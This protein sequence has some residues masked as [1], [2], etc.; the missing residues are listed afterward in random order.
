MVLAGQQQPGV[1][2]AVQ[3]L[4]LVPTPKEEV[5]PL[6]TQE[7]LLPPMALMSIQ[8]IIPMAVMVLRSKLSQI[9]S[10]L[11]PLALDYSSWDS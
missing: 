1:I 4:T 2:L 9:M 7:K 6:P 3:V 8:E 11:V 10:I 5:I